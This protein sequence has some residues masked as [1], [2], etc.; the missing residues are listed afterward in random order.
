[1]KD[2]T[3]PNNDTMLIIDGDLILYQKG[4]K[5][6][7]TEEWWVIEADIDRWVAEFFKKFG[8]YN[9]IIYLT[10]KGNFREKSAVTHKYKGNRT[11]DKPRWYEDIKQY[12][13]HMHRTKLVEGMEA[14]DAIAMHLTR[15]PNSIHIGIDKD[16]LQ[17]QGWHYRY[18]THNSPEVPLRWISNE[19][20]LELQLTTQKSGKVKK[21]LV[22]GGYKWFYAQMLM[23]DKT[24][25]IYG[26]TGYGDVT[27]YNVLDGAVTERE[28]YERVQQCYEQA[29]E[30]HELRLRENANLLWM[31]RGYDDEGE[32]IM[33]EIPECLEQ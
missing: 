33:W 28:C 3:V 22:G 24:D 25:E 30:E 14:D 6:E 13:I 19:G 32:L 20:F 29:F 5:H 4:F 9:Y 2:E 8:T 7:K 16:L 18:A 23:G 10:G 21:K 31:V 15:N 27:A 17:V 26:P 1:M 11:K 12:L